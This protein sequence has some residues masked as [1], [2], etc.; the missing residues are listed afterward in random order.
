MEK[1]FLSPWPN[2]SRPERRY[3][4]L[5]GLLLFAVYLENLGKTD[6]AL[7]CRISRSRLV[8][9]TME[10]KV[11]KDL[12]SRKM[13]VHLL[14]DGFNLNILLVSPHGNQKNFISV[15]HLNDLRTNIPDD[16]T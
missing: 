4:L 15:S 2:E 7:R 14:S 10:L 16:L 8:F 3:D 6:H 11:F 5:R 1:A 9:L 13:K 12:F